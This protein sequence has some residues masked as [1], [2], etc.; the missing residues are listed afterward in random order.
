[1]P[2]TAHHGLAVGRPLTL[3][4]YGIDLDTNQNIIIS[5]RHPIVM[6]AEYDYQQHK[7]IAKQI[8]IT[9]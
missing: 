3:E 1:M 6:G 2:I 7:W 4:A 5:L 9:E 8:P